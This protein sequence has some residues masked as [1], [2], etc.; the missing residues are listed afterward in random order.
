MASSHP[1]E[2]NLRPAVEIYTA[3][4]CG[5]CA[6]LCVV[7]PWMLALAPSVG[8]GMASGFVVFGGHRFIQAW[9]VVRYRR[10][11]RRLPR[12]AVSSR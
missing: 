2:A 6:F 12:F 11:M 5:L 1:I 10:G 3:Y 4:A 9:R 8:Y 7:S